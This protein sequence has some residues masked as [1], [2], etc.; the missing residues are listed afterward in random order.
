MIISASITV[1]L[2]SRRELASYK[3]LDED[4]DKLWEE[5]NRD[6]NPDA[7]KAAINKAV[8]FVI[9]KLQ[10]TTTDDV[11]NIQATTKAELTT[12]LSETAITK[13]TPNQKAALLK[14]AFN[15]EAEH[16]RLANLRSSAE[17]FKNVFLKKLAAA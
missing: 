12:F 13:K 10:L 14:A 2:D 11:K 15:I 1:G 3:I 9:T 8:R 7:K 17:Y 4:L 16:P 6:Q 5:I